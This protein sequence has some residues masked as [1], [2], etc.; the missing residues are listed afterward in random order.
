[1]GSACI[2]DG[3]LVVVDE[4]GTQLAWDNE[5]WL[6]NCSRPKLLHEWE[7]CNATSI[8]DSGTFSSSLSSVHTIT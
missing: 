8:S 4:D 6:H 5:N 7:V 1:M 2:L 3:E